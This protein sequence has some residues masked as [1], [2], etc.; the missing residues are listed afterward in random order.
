M[1]WHPETPSSVRGHISHK[2]FESPLDWTS[3]FED[4]QSKNGDKY[5]DNS[6]IH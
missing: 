1:L 6:Q 2:A 4:N 5:A 3:N